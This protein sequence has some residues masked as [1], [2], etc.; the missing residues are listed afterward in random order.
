IGILKIKAAIPTGKD[1]Y[2]PKDKT[3]SG[4]NFLRIRNDWRIPNGNLSRDGIVNRVNFLCHLPVEILT[5]GI[6]RFVIVLNSKERVLL[7][8]NTYF[9]PI[10]KTF[11]SFCK[12]SITARA[13]DR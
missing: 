8:S 3:T 5:N 6:F 13:G 9:L 1:K 4:L 12:A 2:P 10:N 7:P 11:T